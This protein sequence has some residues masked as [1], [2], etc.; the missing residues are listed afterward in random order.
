[1]PSQAN[2]LA[3]LALDY[4][5]GAEGPQSGK[6]DRI[7]ETP[8]G[9]PPVALGPSIAYCNL[10][11]EDGEPAE[12]GP[13]LPHDDIY[14]EY[15]EG[16]PDPAGQGF[17][18]NIVEQL[19]RCKELGHTLVEQDNPDSYPLYAVLRAIDLAQQRRLGVIAKNPGLMKDGALD[20]VA[21]QNVFGIIVEKDCGSAQEMDA[22]RR[23]AN[24]PDLPV[25][26]VSFGDGRSWARETAQDIQAACYANMGVTYSASGE[27]GSSDDVLLP[28]PARMP[29]PAA[30]IQPR[31]ATGMDTTQA[32]TILSNIGLLDPPA[33]GALGP[34]TRWALSEFCSSAGVPFDGTT[35]TDAVAQALTAATALPLAPGNDLAGH[36]VSAMQGAGY[37]IARH[38]DCLNIAYVEG[39]NADGTPNGNRPNYF[40]S[41]RCVI[42]IGDGGVPKIVGIWEATTEPSRYWTENPMSPGG[43]ARIAFG[44]YKSWVVGDYHGDNALI[45][46]ADITI[47][48]DPQKLYKRYGPPSTGEFGIHQHHGYNYPKNDEGRSSAGCLVGRLND[49]HEEFMAVVKTDARYRASPNYKFLTSILPAQA[50]SGIIT[51]PVVNRPAPPPVPAPLPIGAAATSGD[52][53]FD[54][55]RP[56]YAADWQG[57][58]ILPGRQ[59]AV[60]AIARR[61]ITNKA[62][63]QS[64]EAQT[65]V[66][67]YMI[68]ALHMRESD[69]DFSTHLHNGDPLTGRTYHVPAGRP[70][71]G[72]PPFRW[73]ESAIDALTMHGFNAIQDWPIERV[74]YECEKYNGWGYRHHGV[75]SAYL[76]SFSNVYHGGKYV[77]DG[78][79]SASAE[80]QQCGVMPMINRMMALDASISVA[81]G[82]VQP[83]QP[84]QP[85]VIPPPIIVQPPVVQ[86]PVV[87]PVVQP[88]VVQP[89]VVQPPVVQPPVQW[90]QPAPADWLADIYRRIQQLEKVVTDAAAFA[91][92]LSEV[93]TKVSQLNTQL[94]GLRLPQA[95]VAGT[96]PILSP[97]DKL[98]GGEALVGLKTPMA[99]AAYAGLWILQALGQVGTATGDKATTTGQVLTGLIAAFG[100]LGLS[101]KIDRAVKA[102]SAIA[103]A[104]QNASPPPPGPGQG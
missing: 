6:E 82:P 57:M 87:P 37:F 4:L 17:E 42:R 71:T 68:A 89:P 53:V 97:I 9:E 48:R 21:H 22:L 34:V 67:W 54:G 24:K 63:Y 70:R 56:E 72:S 58:A 86:P 25:W 14:R 91:P 52:S 8:Y 85:P 39:L 84:P 2:P 35:I 23:R 61:L 31:G 47:Y 83:P 16:R 59:A 12:Y 88:P 100:G 90:P 18:R 10:R 30:A 45:Q 20:Y 1:M 73:E 7:T 46:A 93:F 40:D 19:D 75:P 5:I 27:Y 15:H 26:F 77:A 38:K 36:V 74:A 95:G 76:W 101:A 78:V 60:D 102:M 69:A 29:Q 98:L 32:Q 55:Y 81:A 65:G 80:D 94:G 62:R 104:A 79:W 44:Q 51:E 50:L 103:G 49:G 41:V 3:G 28:M 11:R 92:Q 99:I 64:I 13:Y 96:P 43:A 33:D 66:P